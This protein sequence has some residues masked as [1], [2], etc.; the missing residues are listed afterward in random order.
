MQQDFANLPT[1]Y[2]VGRFSSG[3]TWISDRPFSLMLA[4]VADPKEKSALDP[5]LEGFLADDSG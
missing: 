5:S 3:R 4:V 1:F 2:F